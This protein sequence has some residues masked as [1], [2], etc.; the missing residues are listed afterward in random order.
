MHTEKQI[1]FDDYAKKAN[2]AG[3]CGELCANQKNHL[4]DKFLKD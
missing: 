4:T 3:S 1:I 2:M